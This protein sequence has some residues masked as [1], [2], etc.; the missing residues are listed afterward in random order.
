MCRYAVTPQFA[1]SDQ[2]TNEHINPGYSVYQPDLAN[3]SSLFS[4]KKIKAMNKQLRTNKL[5][6]EARHDI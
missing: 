5:R 4:R 3:L 1:H 6:K 2:V